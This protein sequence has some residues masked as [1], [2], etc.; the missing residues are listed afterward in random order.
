M[1]IINIFN[2]KNDLSF[3]V[4]WCVYDNIFLVFMFLIIYIMF[5]LKVIKNK[6][7]LMYIFVVNY[8][9]F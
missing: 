5:L 8:D 3:V 4:R 1:F 9:I 7:Y 6:N 2:M